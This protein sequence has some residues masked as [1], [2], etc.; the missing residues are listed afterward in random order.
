MY[1]WKGGSKSIYAMCIFLEGI[2]V[3]RYFFV[4]ITQSELCSFTFL[5]FSFQLFN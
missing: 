2:L 1:H 4:C 5:F 3:I